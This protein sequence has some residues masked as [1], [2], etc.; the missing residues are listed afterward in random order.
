MFLNTSRSSSFSLPITITITLPHYHRH[1]TASSHHYQNLTPLHRP[2]TT[3]LP[4]IHLTIT[5]TLSSLLHYHH[6]RADI[7]N[8]VIQEQGY[9]MQDMVGMMGSSWNR[10]NIQH[11]AHSNHPQIQLSCSAATHL[12]I[13]PPQHITPFNQL[14]Y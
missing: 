4:T 8:R 9:Q 14:E 7:I 3:T 5:T 2:T 1:L 10:Y 6:P 12:L 11:T 13:T